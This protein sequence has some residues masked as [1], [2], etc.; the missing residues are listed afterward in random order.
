M[1]EID[2]DVLNDGLLLR[3]VKNRKPQQAIPK[4]FIPDL[5]ALVFSHLGHPGVAATT[6]IS[7][8]TEARTNL[9]GGGAGNT[10]ADSKTERGLRGCQN[11]K[12]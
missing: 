2:R 8:R 7:G 9:N 12:R 11:Y 4:R 5:L 1:P 6:S 3:H 10:K